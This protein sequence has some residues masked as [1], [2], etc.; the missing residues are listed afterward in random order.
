MLAIIIDIE[1]MVKKKV[2]K[3]PSKEIA[4]VI[5]ADGLEKINERFLKMLSMIGLYSEDVMK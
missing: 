2:V 1:H 4:V 3:D 5:L